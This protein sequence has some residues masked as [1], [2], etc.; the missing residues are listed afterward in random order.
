MKTA[1]TIV[2][3]SSPSVFA[4]SLL[5]AIS[6]GAKPIVHRLLSLP[7]GIHFR[8]ITWKWFDEG[9][10]LLTAALLKGCSHTIESLC[11]VSGLSCT[12]VHI[13]VHINNSLLLLVKPGSAP[14]NLSKATKLRD[15]TFR[16]GSWNAKWIT[17]ALQTITPKHRDLRQISV[18]LPTCWPP[19]HVDAGTSET[20][21]E[22]ALVQWPDLDRLLVKFWESRLIRPRVIYPLVFRT[23]KG[24]MPYSGS[25]KDWIRRLL[26]ETMGRGIIDLVGA[27]Y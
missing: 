13:C 8:G 6:E 1:L 25:M 4:A 20:S 21:E 10:V 12:S 17:M 14:V 23:T 5:L 9:D 2:E 26:P 24:G 15:A 11:I 3:P 16:P 19:S 22:A 7:G 18:H 27:H